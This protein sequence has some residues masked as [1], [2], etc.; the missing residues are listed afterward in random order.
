MISKQSKVNLYSI[1]CSTGSQRR[2]MKHTSDVG[3]SGSSENES[4]SIVLDLLEFRRKILRT[5]GQRSNAHNNFL[6]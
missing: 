3:L 1:L 4:G 2:D 6:G 5:A